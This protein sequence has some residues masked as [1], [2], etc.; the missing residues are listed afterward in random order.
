MKPVGGPSRPS[1]MRSSRTTDLFSAVTINNPRGIQKTT[2]IRLF[3]EKKF[4]FFHFSF[5]APGDISMKARPG[6][7]LL[8]F[9]G[10]T[11]SM[12]KRRSQI[13]T[14]YANNLEKMKIFP[15]KELNK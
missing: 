1:V 12:T 6:T 4:I 5:G 7:R 14:W 15:E 11:P 8:R 10:P 13:P 2:R 3:T 9:F